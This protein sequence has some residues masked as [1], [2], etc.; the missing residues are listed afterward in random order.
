MVLP[1]GF[2]EAVRAGE[3]PPLT[4]YVNQSRPERDRTVFQQVLADELSRLSGQEEPA[5]VD[6]QVVATPAAQSA[7]EVLSL[8]QWMLST[9]LM[10]ALSMVGVMTIPYLLVEEKE[11]RTLRALLVSPASFTDVALAKVATG[12]CYTIATALLM[13]ALNGGFRG[14]V[15][16]V[17]LVVVLTGLTMTQIGLLIGGVCR[18]LMQVGTWATVA[19]VPMMLPVI[20]VGGLGGPLRHVMRVVPTWYS[21]DAIRMGMASRAPAGDLALDLAMLIA[22]PLAA[23]GAV[24]WTLQRQRR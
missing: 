13:L 4:L 24:V 8:R 7:E 21:L 22:F 2:D 6:T 5:R 1:P 19:F 12:L 14:N 11:K 15:P 20:A 9:W 18:N 16:L 17:L 10:M 3:K 23:F